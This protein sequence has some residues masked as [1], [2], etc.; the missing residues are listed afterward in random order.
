MTEELEIEAV[1][2]GPLMK[3]DP[4]WLVLAGVVDGEEVWYRVEAFAPCDLYGDSL[5]LGSV[6]LPLV[7]E[8]TEFTEVP[9]YNNVNVAGLIPMPKGR[10]LYYP[11]KYEKV[12]IEEAR[13]AMKVVDFLRV[14]DQKKA[15]DARAYDVVSKCE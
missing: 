3:A 11:A 2:T 4:G 7:P 5:E 8:I 6:V 1:I 10:L 13:V 14:Q 15:N 12:Q 9:G